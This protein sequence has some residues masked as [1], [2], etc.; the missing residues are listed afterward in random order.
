M[1][2]IGSPYRGYYIPVLVHSCEKI[3]SFINMYVVYAGKF[4]VHK[5]VQIKVGLGVVYYQRY[6]AFLDIFYSTTFLR[7]TNTRFE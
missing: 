7:L 5:L 3:N 1:G 6:F 2:V 4:T